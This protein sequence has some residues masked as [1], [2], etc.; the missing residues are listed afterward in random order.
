MRLL[1]RASSIFDR[2]ITL[3]AI[4]AAVLLIFVTLAV[5]A[6]IVMRYFF[7]H[8]ILGVVEVT[9]YC[10]LWITF[11]VAAWVLKRGGHIRM[12]LILGHLKPRI[13]IMLNVVT[14]IICALICLALTWYGVAVTWF[15]FQSDYRLSTPLMPP[16]APIIV[17]I[18][19]GAL[20]LFI[21]FLRVA[22]SHIELWKAS[23]AINN[24]G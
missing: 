15:H 10:L 23:R 16:S 13:R 3:F 6:E 8:P 24:E 20:L 9:E 19:I 1:T 21:Q 5:L 2:I 4:L 14:S 11:L 17:I 22:Y 12:D 18:P 7:R